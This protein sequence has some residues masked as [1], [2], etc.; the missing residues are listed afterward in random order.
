MESFEFLALDRAGQE[1]TGVIDAADEPSV[2]KILRNRNLFPIEVSA[3]KPERIGLKQRFLL[4]S[5]V[6][7]EHLYHFSRELSILLKSGMRLDQALELLISSI[8]NVTL[9]HQTQEVL[10]AV[11][12][13]QSLT[14]ALRAQSDIFGEDY[15]SIVEIGEKTGNLS[16]SFKSISNY[17]LFRMEVFSQIKN[18]MVYPIFL[19]G[20]SVIVVGVLFLVVIPKFFSAFGNQVT[21]NLPLLS[22]TMLLLST[23]TR[24]HMG[25]VL[26]VFVGVVMF[27]FRFFKSKRGNA[28]VK[29]V[30]TKLPFIK[31]LVLTMDISKFS[32]T[33]ALL[34][35]SGVEILD[36][37]NLSMK[38]VRT[39][40]FESG[41]KRLIQYVKE[42]E[43]MGPALQEIKGLPST[44]ISMVKVGEESGNLVEVLEEVYNIFSLQF[45]NKVKKA[46]SLF[47]PLLIATVA[48]IVG[49]VIVSIFMT[50][51]SAY[52]I[53]F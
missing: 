11:K 32:Y 52:S 13:G 17:L 14:E 2:I 19:L 51:I 27:L 1:I 50:I 29:D 30:V 33:F 37:L 45:Q 22:R 24:N 28:F 35:K 26:V 48:I 44:F 36:A 39:P 21:G 43:R 53:Q 23:F 15:L 7:E 40:F 3:R 42:G 31:G 5:K 12:K 8:G 6:K 46:L 18:A 10:K 38:G 9:K 34:L 25:G 41:I 20:A 47:E 4:S 16:G 49:S